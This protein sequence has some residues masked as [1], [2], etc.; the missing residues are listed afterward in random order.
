M[1]LDRK[2]I[3]ALLADR[4][5]SNVD[6]AARMKISRQQWGNIKSGLT[7]PPNLATVELICAA[8]DCGIDE[9][10]SDDSPAMPRRRLPARKTPANG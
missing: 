9:L 4:G 5:L 3:D 8:I 6:V 7:G 1:G 2:K 10:L